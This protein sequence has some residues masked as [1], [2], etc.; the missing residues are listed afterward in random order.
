MTNKAPASITLEYLRQHGAGILK[1][2]EQF[3]VQNIRVFGSVVRAETTPQSDVDLM[4]DLTRE[5]SLFDRIDFVHALEDVLGCQVDVAIAS[6]LKD[7]IREHAL[8]DAIR[9]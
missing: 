1:I 4:I 9:L 2:A 7:I 3:G 8:E 6:H 5:W